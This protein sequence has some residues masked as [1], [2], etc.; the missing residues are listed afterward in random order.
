MM[1]SWPY[2]ARPSLGPCRHVVRTSSRPL[3]TSSSAWSAAASSS[4][5]STRQHHLFCQMKLSFLSNKTRRTIVTTR[6]RHEMTVTE[7]PDTNIILLGTSHT[8]TTHEDLL[9]KFKELEP[10][11]EIAVEMC[12]DRLGQLFLGQAR[13]GFQSVR[14]EQLSHRYE[15]KLFQRIETLQHGRDMATAA[16]FSRFQLRKPVLLL[17]RK[18]SQTLEALANDVPYAELEK[19]FFWQPLTWPWTVWRMQ[20]AF[21]EYWENRRKLD[22]D[23][24]QRSAGRSGPNVEKAEVVPAHAV[25]VPPDP[26]ASTTDCVKEDQQKSFQ[27]AQSE[28]SPTSTRTE[29]PPHLTWSELARIA[30]VPNVWRG[31]L[32]SMPI[33]LHECQ[34]W[35]DVEHVFRKVRCC[36]EE[37]ERSLQKVVLDGRDGYMAKQLFWNRRYNAGNEG[38]CVAVVGDFHVAGMVAELERLREEERNYTA[39]N[40]STCSTNT[41]SSTLSSMKMNKT[42]VPLSRHEKGS[43]SCS[44]KLNSDRLADKPWIV[45]KY[46]ERQL[47]FALGEIL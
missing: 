14:G 36:S 3:A 34:S 4:S 27:A 6:P 8:E 39:G 37:L 21:E 11:S 45:R 23:V 26:A 42:G 40:A 19:Q 28:N 7:V 41:T 25:K 46:F 29:D 20:L 24:V 35:V 1:P 15:Q 12:E 9:E 32:A 5:S 31:F 38:K 44:G 43:S 47:K 30:K 16:W 13:N 33:A 10:I 22:L 17:D 18:F 2:H